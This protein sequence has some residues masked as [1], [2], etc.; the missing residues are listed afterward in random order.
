MELVELELV[1]LGLVK[2]EHLEGVVVFAEHVLIK[3]EGFKI[4]GNGEW[5]RPKITP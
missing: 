5:I 2:E 3:E 1:K 4:F